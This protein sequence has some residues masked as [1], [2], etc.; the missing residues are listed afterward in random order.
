[1]IVHRDYRDSSGSIIKIYDDKI[2]FFNPGGLYGNLTKE[3]LL[4][5]NYQP[6]ARNKLIAKAFKEIGKVEK[7]GS[8]MKRI[9]TICEEYGII[10]PQI[11]IKENSFELV[12]FKEKVS[13]G[14]IG[15]V[16]G[17]VSGGVNMDPTDKLFQLIKSQPN[18]RA[19]ELALLMNTP[20]KTIEKWIEK[21]RKEKRI[22][23]IGSNKKGG[24][25]VVDK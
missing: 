20:Y 10:A 4:N 11:N 14:V 3:E 21:L 17:G 9:F 16:S 1:M 2:E 13:G 15:G 25:F 24:Y 8:G 12:L 5:F 22:E 7:Y 23:F 19:N 6:Q 18:K